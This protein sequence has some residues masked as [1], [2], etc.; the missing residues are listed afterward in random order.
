MLKKF[1]L[2]F[3]FIYTFLYCNS[4]QFVLSDFI[5]GFWKKVVPSFAKMVSGNSEVAYVLSGSGDTLFD[6]Y[7][8]L[9]LVCIS[10]IISLIVLLVD[11][12]RPDYKSLV[13]WF[14]LILRY[15]IAAQM[16]SYGLAKLFALQFRE[17]SLF[18]LAQPLGDKSPMGLLWTFMGH[19]KTYTIFTG[20]A[21]L[22]GGLFLLSRKTTLLG[23]LIT[24]GVMSNVMMM[25]YCYD[26]INQKWSQ[27]YLM[28]FR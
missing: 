20:F 23:A 21:E 8:V 28:T 3:L 24:F 22:L 27:R 5:L 11:Y 1:A 25:N 4:I 19:S 12:R 16:I 18:N 9:L 26:G 17:P 6:Y 15:Y 7:L 10:L 2:L 13:N 14:L